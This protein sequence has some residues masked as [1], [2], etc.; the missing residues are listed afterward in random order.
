MHTFNSSTFSC[1]SVNFLTKGLFVAKQKARKATDNVRVFL[2]KAHLALFI[3]SLRRLFSS[4]IPGV[5]YFGVSLK[6]IDSIFQV[7]YASVW[8][9]LFS[10]VNI[11]SFST[12]AAWPSG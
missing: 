6:Q 7:F 11:I 8:S 12:E 10:M 1:Q 3:A 9:V 5:L 4:F 2:N